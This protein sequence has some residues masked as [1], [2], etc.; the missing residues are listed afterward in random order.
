M[1]QRRRAY[2]EVLQIVADDMPYVWL[3]FPKEYKLVSARVHGFVHVPD[4]MMRLAR[5]WLSP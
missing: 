1:A 3:Y 5:A 2:R 4:G